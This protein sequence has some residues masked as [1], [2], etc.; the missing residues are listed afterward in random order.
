MGSVRDDGPVTT[1]YAGA[2]AAERVVDLGSSRSPLT[3]L[4]G[5]ALHRWV[6]AGLDGLSA[7]RA[8]IDAL[9]VYPL[10]DGDTGSNMLLTW[11]AVAEG[12]R[13]AG[14][15]ARTV[16]EAARRGA[17]LGARGNSGVILCQWLT[18]LLDALAGGTADGAAVAA[19]LAT[20]GRVAP[21]AV[22]DPAAGTILT[23]AAAA[24]TAAPGPLETVV[25]AA[26]ANARAALAATP[27]QL[28]AL[29]AAGVVDAGGRGLV[30]LL[31]A[32]EAVVRGRPL[33]H[34]PPPGGAAGVLRALVAARESGSETFA[35]EVQYLLAADADAIPA[36][37]AGLEPLGDSLVVVG[38]GEGIWN[39][40][41]HV[42][43]VGAA[44]ER[45]VEAGR[46]YRVTVTRF[47]DQARAAERPAAQPAGRAVVTVAAGAGLAALL[48]AEGAVV[49]PGAPQPSV[50]DLLGAALASGAGEVVILPGD[51]ELLATAQQ[52]A[53]AVRG[54]D[55]GRT[56]VVVPT[57]S[58]VQGLAALAVRQPGRAFG[59]D[60]VAMAEAA[61]ATRTGAVVVATAEAL[62]SAGHCVPGDVLG[63]I[64]RDV[65]LLGR[66]V[67]TV[68]TGLLDRMLAGGGEL[69]TVVLGAAQG[70]D[71]AD[72]VA[73][74]LEREHPF[75]EVCV[76]DG[77]QP[78]ALLLGVE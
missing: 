27:E 25:G 70:P 57:A 62:T 54:D 19:A 73:A 53:A 58:P 11:Q 23:V 60:V 45:G 22:A 8:E 18:G 47:A 56:V 40:H 65:A 76:Y 2:V 66:D 36:L 30:V 29:A 50:G 69:V 15:D 34:V 43:D 75:V 17:L 52:A 39:V 3:H 48:R 67:A 72:A 55:P 77:G 28:P 5:A 44:L 14:S 32:L 1:P 38:N 51:G 46:P 61:A 4:D 37:R 49:V 24:G 26:A 41:V 68:A 6:A 74:H 31:E 59:D 33:L 16:L 35:Y 10:P 42:N 78:A 20:A 71:V 13:G 64:D 63:V 21:T 7:G 9:N 12:V